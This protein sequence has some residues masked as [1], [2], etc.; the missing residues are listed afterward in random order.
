MVGAA[1]STLVTREPKPKHPWISEETL[2]KIEQRARTA[3]S[4]NYAE[5]AEWDKAIKKAAREDRRK[6]FGE[7]MT[8]SVWDP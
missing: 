6:W 4:G 5:A 7:K 8:G 3:E 1:E 2:R